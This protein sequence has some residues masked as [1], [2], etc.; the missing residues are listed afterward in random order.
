MT[1]QFKLEM[2]SPGIDRLKQNGGFDV[3]TPTVS[4]SCYEQHLRHIWSANHV[5]TFKM[6]WELSMSTPWDACKRLRTNR[7]EL[8]GPLPP[9]PVTATACHSEG[10]SVEILSFKQ[11]GVKAIKNADD[12]LWSDKLSW[13]RKCAYTKMGWHH[14]EASWSF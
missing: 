14:F 8:H 13:E 5:S 10:S 9:V 4:S 11:I 3:T 6:P 7:L 2:A 12:R 1:H